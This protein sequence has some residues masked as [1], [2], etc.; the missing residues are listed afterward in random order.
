[1]AV[2]NLGSVNIDHFYAVPHLPQPGET[3]QAR[4]HSIGLGGKGTNQSVAAAKAGAHV[5]HIGAIGSGDTWVRERIEGYGVDCR[6]L[7]GL[8]TDT[9]HAIIYVDDHGENVIV[10]D[11]GANWQLDAG[12]VE[13]ALAQATPS[14][15]L[16][17]QNETTLQAQAAEQASKAG[18][19]V[20]YSA[21]PF[22]VDAV[23]AV[24]PSVTMLVMNE[25]E[26][27][28]LCSALGVTVE[29][30]PV[31]EVIVTLG[32][33]GAKWRSNETG[34]SHVVAAPRVDAVDTTAAGDTYIGYVAAGLDLG[35]S[36]SEAMEWAAKAAALKVTRHG[37]AD[38]I[39][40]ADE[41]A[42]FD[43]A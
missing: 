22:S 7:A 33:K 30:I 1:M 9:G 10:L 24:L 29:T 6:F 40:S 3:L 42:R 20:I 4:S 39:P 43:P 35:K 16:M 37:T 32:S 38:A 12:A 11:P 17:I 21:A 36:V 27:E 5:S 18:I 23:R 19:R 28:Q 41:V 2:Y 31:P 14:D 13:Q 8:D 15:T 25:V 34:E 26:A